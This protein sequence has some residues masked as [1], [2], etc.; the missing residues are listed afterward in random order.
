[1]TVWTLC[2]TGIT[3][4]HHYYCPLRLPFPQ[5]YQVIVSSA[6]LLYANLW[7]TVARRISQLL[8]CPFDTRSLQ[9][10]RVDSMRAHVYF[11]RINNR[12]HHIRQV[13]HQPIM[14]NEA[15]T[16]SLYWGSYLRCLRR[17]NLSS[18]Q[19]SVSGT[20]KF[21]VLHYLHTS[22]RN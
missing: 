16:S 10:P 15:E 18:H 4:R 13:S 11:F 17:T 20:A 6:P 1:M 2:S 22:K 19:N 12:L 14:C 8:R 3:P 21:H 7:H 9:S 5:V